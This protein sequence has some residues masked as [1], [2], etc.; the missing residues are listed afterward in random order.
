M[1]AT[2]RIKADALF[3]RRKNLF[4]ISPYLAFLSS[5]RQAVVLGAGLRGLRACGAWRLA[6]VPARGTV[7][8]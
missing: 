3:V 5:G 6:R 4:M 7:R 1:P 2:P 8:S